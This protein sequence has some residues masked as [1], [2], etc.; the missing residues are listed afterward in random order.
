MSLPL[1]SQGGGPGQELAPCS[2]Q[3]LP[4]MS[5]LL[6]W[7]RRGWWGFQHLG[8]ENKIGKFKK[9]NENVYKHHDFN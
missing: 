3:G 8:N 4:P 9:I 6:P 5:A 2:P 7:G 1:R